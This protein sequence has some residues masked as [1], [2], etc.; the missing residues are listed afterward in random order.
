M[1]L[2]CLSHWQRICGLAGLKIKDLTLEA[3]RQALLRANEVNFR[4]LAPH[5]RAF[6][7]YDDPTAADDG[8]QDKASISDA[9]DLPWE[10]SRGA[11]NLIESLNDDKLSTSEGPFPRKTA[12]P[13]K[14]SKK[15]TSREESGE[16]EADEQNEHEEAYVD[17][18]PEEA[19]SSK[20][21]MRECLFDIQELLA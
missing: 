21:E 2:P 18:T 12:S 1:S 7:R 5:R 4:A 13:R 9:S 10:L 20:Q 8:N 11:S 14:R 17:W 16:N 3:I 15:E 6:V 19:L